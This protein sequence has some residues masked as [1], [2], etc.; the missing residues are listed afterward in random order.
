MYIN[1]IHHK[2]IHPKIPSTTLVLKYI[3]KSSNSITCVILS[4]IYSIRSNSSMFFE[5]FKIINYMKSKA[6]QKYLKQN[7]IK[8]QDVMSIHYQKN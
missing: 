5:F 4:W 8:I 7:K 6:N 3:F 1:I 2:K